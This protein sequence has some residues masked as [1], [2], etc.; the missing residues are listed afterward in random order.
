MTKNKKTGL[1][2][3]AAF[4]LPALIVLLFFVVAHVAPFGD[5]SIAVADARLQYLDY[6][7]YL[8]NVLR[9]EDSFFYSFR[10]FL[11][12]TGI[13][14]FA[15]YLS[16]PFN[17]LI[18][19]FRP[20]QEN[21]F[22]SLVVLLKIATCGLTCCIYL[23]NR[24]QKLA[25][26][27]V[28]LLSTGYAMMQY[29]LVQA[30][31]IMW[32]DGVYLLP[33]LLLGVY[34]LVQTGQSKL[35]IVTLF[36]SLIICWYTGYF[37]CVAVLVYFFFE[38]LVMNRESLTGR[39]K[40]GRLGSIALHSAAGI[41]LSAALFYPV[42]V[43]LG[44][45]KGQLE[46]TFESTFNANLFNLFQG[47]A[48][49]E[50]EWLP[51]L[52]V[53]FCGSLAF[54][55]AGLYFFD[56]RRPSRERLG[57]LIVALLMV[58]F[59][60]YKP[61]ETIINGFRDVWSYAFRFAY[62]VVFYVVF[63]AAAEF[64]KAEEIAPERFLRGALVCT[65][66]MLLSNYI[67]G[68][69]TL[70]RI[71]VSALALVILA[72]LLRQYAPRENRLTRGARGAVAAGM[73][74]VVAAEL[75]VN[76]LMI[77]Q[78]RG[79]CD[80]PSYTAYAERQTALSQQLQAHDD[81]FY[82]VAQT[83][84]RDTDEKT[85]LTADY[86]D[87]LA[88]GYRG[89]SFYASTHDNKQAQ[90]LVDL[91]YSTLVDIG[92]NNTRILS[93]D[94]LLGTKYVFSDTPIRGL[95]PV[96]ELPVQGGIRTYRNP[97][98]LSA[99]VTYPET[100]L[101]AQYTGDPFAY[102]NQLFSQLAGETVEVFRPLNVTAQ[103]SEEGTTYTLPT[104]G[105]DEIVYF[106]AQTDTEINAKVYADGRFLSDYS[107]WLS[108]E[109]LMIPPSGRQSTVL[110]TNTADHEVHAYFY[111]LNLT[112]LKQITDTCNASVATT[113]HIQ[114]GRASFTVDGKAGTRLLLQIPENRG[115]RVFM[116]GQ[117]V[118]DVRTF[119]GCLYSIGLTDGPCEITM[120]YIIP[121]L[122]RGAA[123]SALT[124]VCLIT[125]WVVRRVKR[126]RAAK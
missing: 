111:A 44:E 110:V 28:L 41:G 40:W 58:L 48:V 92:I 10:H 107:C 12:S 105:E 67:G 43:A 54:L 14:T 32:L 39:Q 27:Y 88:Y 35:Y 63:F 7:Q 46:F 2:F 57:S 17:L 18:L 114:N 87:P 31:N 4:C 125:V 75:F 56:K 36:L 73:V 11:G 86:N 89:I 21:A 1:L 106:F 9:G 60:Y 20:G 72:L 82:R 25:P 45:G 61:L 97:F 85:G 104:Y 65:A 66:L 100:A 70:E 96:T 71:A 62:I 78:T 59:A 121:G 16:S 90:A 119:A 47:F 98:A 64:E 37:N 122:K 77:Y 79:L 26:L 101:T 69:S 76:S 120:Y 108:P 13:A 91:G 102:Q 109:S 94:A 116:N 22:F 24:F 29:T 118:E 51:N 33:L 19:A 123:A 74:V 80:V 68:K 103:R 23:K 34:K 30:S 50:G 84:Y 112:T 53:L 3:A 38:L 124:L 49:G 8:R 6:F 42:I 115:W 93:S 99:A 126:R 113:A 95:E 81:T 117:R 15:Y 55:G 83:S 52:L 5:G